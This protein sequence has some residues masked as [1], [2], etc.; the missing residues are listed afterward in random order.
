LRQAGSEPAA[1][2]ILDEALKRQP[3]SATVHFRK[4]NAAMDA[5]RNDEALA[6]FARAVAL[7]PD[8]WRAHLAIATIRFAAG[9]M[10]AAAAA[11]RAALAR[12]PGALDA[13]RIL[14][15]A[16]HALHQDDEVT[17]AFETRLLQAPD[18][19]AVRAELILILQS[20]GRRDAVEQQL[21]EVAQRHAADPHGWRVILDARLADGAAAQL[22]RAAQEALVACSDDPDVLVR[23][24][25][26]EMRLERRVDVARA[27]LERTLKRDPQHEKTL[28]LRAKLP[29]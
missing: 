16:L 24:V 29:R 18:D 8:Y 25:R 11:A 6:E 2:A 10:A 17:Q 1:A 14:A 23:C 21:K 27:L 15:Q 4:A 28:E 26:A 13:M 19:L 3:N 20:L 9:D 5:K 12:E 22:A 7:D